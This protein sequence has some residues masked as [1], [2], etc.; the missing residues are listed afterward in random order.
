MVKSQLKPQL[1]FF[2][3]IDLL[4]QVKVELPSCRRLS[5]LILD[6][7]NRYKRDLSQ[8]IHE[9][10]SEET[11]ILLDQLFVQKEDSRTS[12]YRLTLLKKISQSSKPTKVKERIEDL[13]FIADL[14]EK[15]K[16]ILE[17]TGLKHE[18]I[19]YFAGSVLK[20]QIF[21]LNQRSSED[22]YVHVICFIA[23]QYFR[24]QDNLVDVLL[25]VVRTFH[26]SVQR[27][28]KDLCFDQRKNQTKSISTLL[29]TL[30]KNVFALINEIRSVSQDNYRNDSEK[31]QEIRAILKDDK[32]Q[33]LQEIKKAFAEEI[34]SV[35]YYKILEARSVRLQ[36][37]VSLIIKS[38]K[39]QAEPGA[40]GLVKAIDYFK[41][42][43]G[44]IKT[45]APIG[46]LDKD[47]LKA[48]VTED[49]INPSLY[50][51]FLFIHIA[52]AVKSGLLNLTHSYKYRPLDDYM[53]SKERWEDEKKELLEAAALDNFTDVEKVLKD[54]D[55]NLLE[56]Y[57][58]TNQNI[59]AGKNVHFK[60]FPAGGFR[61]A[62]PALEEKER[63]P[64]QGYFPDRHFVPLTEILYTV[65]RSSKFINQ[66]QHHQQK[67]TQTARKPAM[68]ASL[69]GLGCGIGARKMA[70]ISNSIKENEIEH[71]VNWYL[72]R[73]N[74]QAANDSILKIMDSMELPN[75]YRRH[76]DKLH[77]SS[78]GQKFTVRGESLNANYS[79]KYGGKEQVVSAYSFIDERGLLWYS[80]VFS[81]AE[82]ESAYVIDGLMHNDVV[83]SDIHSTDTHGYSEVIFGTTHL[84]GF[85]YAP[86]IKNLK[87]QALYIFK[88]RKNTNRKE[89]SVKPT[90]YVNEKIIKENW[91][92]LLRL[93]C[94][95]K[96]KETTASDIFR[97]LNSYSKQHD[98]YKAMK[99]FGQIIKSKFILQY[100]N[101]LE[102]RQSIEKQL[103]KVELANKFTRAVAVG[104]P[105]EFTHTNKEEQE[106][107]ESCNRL[108]KNAII[109]WNYMYLTQKLKRTGNE[110]NR[111]RLLTA[112]KNHSPIS[113]AHIN[114]LGEYDFSEER[115]QDSLGVLTYQK[116]GAI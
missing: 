100:L 30:D 55:K 4:R 43:D 76:K 84:L 90:N 38:F 92:D 112:I 64:L 19:K 48:T 94:T 9:S 3:C 95:I 88:S 110:E 1:I 97:R 37:R 70:Q 18:G 28:Y 12:Q 113:W 66:L 47:Q 40:K 99:A 63:D 31:V 33:D 13:N 2:R 6:V 75:I 91:D 78:D 74:L 45:N 116:D 73:E 8:I 67:H 54:L 82:R 72:S 89:W 10:I 96:L 20:S 14:Y 32:C 104:N 79:F 7:L 102:L 103:N 59:E 111:E 85:S 15:I 83:K 80:L 24:L 23:H 77:T 107:A 51:A 57:K 36:N 61:I 115:M 49:K 86:R 114:L 71:I 53:I 101:D 62:T 50:K 87:K 105:R 93:A 52:N 25:S 35:E 22:R 65:N 44:L 5:L 98:L 17:T 39:L 69:M 46:F 27:E 42:K 108:I 56:Q 21:Q 81:A 68:F 29:D 26:N 16:T 58:L 11:Q 106:V 34:T 41:D 109:C 60:P